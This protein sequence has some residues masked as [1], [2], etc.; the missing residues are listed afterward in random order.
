MKPIIRNQRI[1][2]DS[3]QRGDGRLLDIEAVHIHKSTKQPIPI[4]G[5]KRHVE[6]EI[7]LY[8]NNQPVIKSSKGNLE[9]I[10]RQLKDELKEAFSNKRQVEDFAKEVL[11]T[12]QNY[13]GWHPDEL[14]NALRRIASIIGVVWSEEQLQTYTND[15]LGFVCHLQLFDKEDKTWYGFALCNRGL[16]IEDIM[17]DRPY[18]YYRPRYVIADNGR[19]NMGKSTAIKTVWEILSSRYPHNIIKNDYDIKGIIQIGKCI[20]GIE[21]QGDPNSRM[22][23][24]MDDFVQHGCDI[25]LTACRTRGETYDKLFD[26]NYW[27]NYE[28]ILAPNPHPYYYQHNVPF[29]ILMEMDIHYSESLVRTIESIISKI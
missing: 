21:S 1:R 2:I 14:I 24:S 4:D 10:P 8:G 20:V 3:H 22:Q 26:L 17:S 13:P 5:Q 19:S 15:V 25:I 7:P 16:Q 27:Y 6:I 12:L 23:D 11:S 9:D 18:D 29:D 28:I